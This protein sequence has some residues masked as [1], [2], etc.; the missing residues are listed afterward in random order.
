MCLCVCINFSFML[1]DRIRITATDSPSVPLI[2]IK[3][4]HS[5]I[6]NFE[7]PNTLGKKRKD[8]SKSKS[9]S[10]SPKSSSPTTPTSLKKFCLPKLGSQSKLSKSMLTLDTAEQLAD[11][12]NERCHSSLSLS[13]SSSSQ[14]PTTLK[15]KNKWL[16]KLF[17]P[18]SAQKLSVESVSSSGGEKSKKK[19]FFHKKIQRRS[20]SREPVPDC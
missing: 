12:E 3:Q 18:A 4:D 7:T 5:T 19:T 16:K 13:N 15:K 6:L 9:K 14:T 11:N 17:S 8:K 10:I 1:F 2:E 20:K